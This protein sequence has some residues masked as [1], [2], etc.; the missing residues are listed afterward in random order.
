LG[1]VKRKWLST[2]QCGYWKAKEM[3]NE[4]EIMD[5]AII[6]YSLQCL[7]SVVHFG[8]DVQKYVVSSEERDLPVDRK[9]KLSVVELFGWNPLQEAIPSNVVDL[10]VNCHRRSPRRSAVCKWALVVVAT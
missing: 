2:L 10:C 4:Q 3:P 1:V 5:A 6:L 8:G 7:S 9:S